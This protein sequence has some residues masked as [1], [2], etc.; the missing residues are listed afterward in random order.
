MF[1]HPLCCLMF[2]AG[3]ALREYGAFN[4]AI[5]KPN[6]SVYI[7]STCLIYMAPYVTDSKEPGIPAQYTNA[8]DNSPLL[9]LANYHVL[10]RILYY[11]PYFSPLHPGRVLTSFGILSSIVEVLNAVGAS[12]TANIYLPERFRVVG[13]GFAKASLILQFVVIALFC[14]LAGVVHHRCN[15]AG[16]SSRRIQ[17]PFITLYISTCLI[18]V[19]T[20]Y[21]TVE[22]FGFSDVLNSGDVTNFSPFLRNEWYFWVFEASLMLINSVLW[23]VRHPRRYLPVSKKTY[24]AQDGITDIDGPGWGDDRNFL[25]TVLDPFGTCRTRKE[26]EPKQPPFWETNEHAMPNSEV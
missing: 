13:Y 26:S 7:A 5:T 20:I 3:F 14:V 9:E 11:V 18:T 24:L 4:Y 12:Y 23:N 2:A 21:R 8:P 22:Y 15:K 16:I 6:L 19:R 1:L 17:G 10:G 25:I